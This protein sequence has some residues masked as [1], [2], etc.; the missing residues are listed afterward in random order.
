MGPLRRDANVRIGPL[1]PADDHRFTQAERL[2]F[3][4]FRIKAVAVVVKG[5]LAGVVA[6]FPV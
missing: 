2:A 5:F 4:S 6:N 3:I 1:E